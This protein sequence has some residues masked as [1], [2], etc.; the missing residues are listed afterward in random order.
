ME[1]ECLGTQQMVIYKAFILL[2]FLTACS[3][4]G[5]VSSGGPT[6]NSP[7]FDERV[8]DALVYLEN[9]SPSE[10]AFVASHLKGYVE[11]PISNVVV[12][13]GIFTIG[14]EQFYTVF[15][16]ASTFIHESEH[17]RLYKA[18][19]VYTGV[20]AELVCNARQARYLYSIGQKYSADYVAGADGRHFLE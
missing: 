19:D 10:S 17:V 12:E 18:G 2:L 20:S 5:G 16:L 7:S 3:R 11:G 14:P 4:G 1:M 13:T 6:P 9:T 8:Q 15:W